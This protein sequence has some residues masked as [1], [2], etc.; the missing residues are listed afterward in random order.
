MTAIPWSVP[1]QV[2]LPERAINSAT[3]ELELSATS[4]SD[5]SVTRGLSRRRLVDAIES[6]AREAA[7][8]NWDGN[9]ARPVESTTVAFARHFAAALPG[10]LP[11]PDVS[12]DADGDLSFDWNYG[13]R[14]V[15]SVSVR[16]DGILNYAGLHGASSVHGSE[17][18][19]GGLPPQL[20]QQ[21]GRIAGV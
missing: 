11:L 1:G 14:R 13:P 12:A 3:A 4:A 19:F 21:I 18:I 20:V 7:A 5:T 6:A 15:F 9:G 16:R 17:T 2:A 10:H 8:P